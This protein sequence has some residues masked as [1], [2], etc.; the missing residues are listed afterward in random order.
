M[1]KKFLTVSMATVMILC[2]A[3]CGKKSETGDTGT[4]VSQVATESD[5]AADVKI[6]SEDDMFS[7]RDYEISYDDAEDIILADG[8]SSSDA[9]GVEIDG[10]TITI[11]KAGSY[12]LSGSLSDGQIIV[13]VADDEKVQLVLDGVDIAN[14]DSAAIYVKNADKVFITTT[15]SDNSLSVTGD[16]EESED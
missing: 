13:D 15:E 14:D 10:D 9:S 11:T 6:V 4:T 1:I 5:T 2:M 7:D 8:D 16:F 3:G 12:K